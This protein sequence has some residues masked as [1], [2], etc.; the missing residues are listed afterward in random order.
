MSKTKQ[1]LSVTQQ[2]ARGSWR[3][4]PISITLCHCRSSRQQT[5]DIKLHHI[6]VGSSRALASHPHRPHPG[7][8]PD[9]DL[10]PFCSFL[11]GQFLSPQATI[12]LWAS[13]HTFLTGYA[14]TLLSLIDFHNAPWRDAIPLYHT[15]T[16]PFSMKQVWVTFLCILCILLFLGAEGRPSK[17]PLSCIWLIWFISMFIRTQSELYLPLSLLCKFIFPDIASSL[18]FFTLCWS[19]EVVVSHR[20]PGCC[21][22]IEAFSCEASSLTEFFTL[23]FCHCCSLERK[24]LLGS[25]FANNCFL[26]QFTPISRVVVKSSF[27]FQGMLLYAT[28]PK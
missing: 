22:V 8:N 15:L 25:K 17:F 24:S 16:F 23:L 21:G 4:P 11:R 14:P 12:P 9:Q 1:Y 20:K 7:T 19:L 18:V 26:E 28:H 6:K 10:T 13:A 27:I 2:C 3:C 5:Q